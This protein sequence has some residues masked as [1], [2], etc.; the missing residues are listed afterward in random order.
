MA[1]PFLLRWRKVIA[2]EHGPAAPTTRHVLLTLSVYMRQDGDCYPSTRELSAATGLSERSVCTH[3][4][5][6]QK[7]GWINRR[8]AGSGRAWKHMAY[9]ATLPDALKEVQHVGTEGGS[10]PYEVEALNVVPEGTEPDDN[11]ALKEVQSNSK[12]ELS[13]NSIT[14]ARTPSANGASEDGQQVVARLNELLTTHGLPG[15]G[16]WGA[17]RKIADAALKRVPVQEALDALAWAFENDFWRKRFAAEEMKVLKSAW[18]DWKER[19]KLTPIRGRST[20]QDSAGDGPRLSSFME[21][22]V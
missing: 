8:L 16:N 20:Y 1:Q 22:V 9:Q 19:D 4:D 21:S 3:L 14:D 5:I 15:I 6:A 13:K 11:K 12:R 10:A 7:D 2:S 18:A 17:A